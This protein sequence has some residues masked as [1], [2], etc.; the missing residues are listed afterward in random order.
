MRNRFDDTCCPSTGVASSTTDV[1]DQWLCPMCG[2]LPI[3]PVRLEGGYACAAHTG[4]CT[5][6]GDPIVPGDDV[7]HHCE[8]LI[9]T[10]T[11]VRVPA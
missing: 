2:Q 1:G 5:V 7:C 6:C 10:S 11:C 4:A 9:N 3:E 8:L